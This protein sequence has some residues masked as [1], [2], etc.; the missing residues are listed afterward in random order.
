MGPRPPCRHVRLFHGS[1]ADTTARLQPRSWYGKPGVRRR[2]RM[3]RGA[4]GGVSESMSESGG[5][6]HRQSRSHPSVAHCTGRPHRS[7]R[8]C[9]TNSR[10]TDTRPTGRR[11]FIHRS[12]R[13]IHDGFPCIGG[14]FAVIFGSRGPLPR[15]ALLSWQWDALFLLHFFLASLPRQEKQKESRGHPDAKTC[16]AGA[17][18]RPSGRVHSRVRPGSPSPVDTSRGTLARPPSPGMP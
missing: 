2:R 4:V 16:S 8:H 15:P 14:C 11:Q 3:P 1:Y 17:C 7:G 18:G 6:G 5:F 13:S 10:S 9:S 12:S